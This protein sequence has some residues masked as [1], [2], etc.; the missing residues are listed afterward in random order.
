VNLAAELAKADRIVQAVINS[1]FDRDML[2]NRLAWESLKR[3][4]AQRLRND[5]RERKSWKLN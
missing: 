2:R 1:N 3:S 5:G 4:Q